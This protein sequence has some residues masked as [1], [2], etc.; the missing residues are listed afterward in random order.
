MVVPFGSDNEEKVGFVLGVGE[1]T[2]SNA[3]YPP[4]HTKYVARLFG[5]NEPDKL[6]KQKKLLENEREKYHSDDIGFYS[7]LHDGG[8]QLEYVFKNDIVRYVSA[9]DVVAIGSRAF[10][11]C[12]N[13]TEIVLQ[14]GIKSFA[15]D[16]L[17]KNSL[18]KNIY[19]SKTVEYIEPR[20]YV[21]E[22][23]DNEQINYFV[24]EE[25][26]YLFRDEDSIYKVLPNGTYKLVKCMY[27]GKGRML[28][29]EGT[30]EIGERAF[31]GRMTLKE[32]ILPESVKI[33]ASGAFAATGLKKLTIPKHIKRIES[34]AFKTS[35]LESVKIPA[36]IKY[37]AEDAFGMNHGLIVK[38][39]YEK[40]VFTYKNGRLERRGD[41]HAV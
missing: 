32:L 37:I 6:V 1:Y 16:S 30:S 33:I 9:P 15:E 38:S 11:Q 29:L 27:R 24:D 18:T 10:C 31:Q 19:L 22:E 23:T 25:N 20:N 34:E 8:K 26:K 12:H 13:L 28:V 5:D 35:C 36:N 41:Y 3:P 39:L 4:A 2:K 7:V 40:N 21:Y 17:A 14:D